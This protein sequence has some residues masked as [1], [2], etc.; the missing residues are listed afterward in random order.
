[1]SNI[2]KYSVITLLCVIQTCGV[3]WE[4]SRY[5][6]QEWSVFSVAPE[7]GCVAIFTSY[8]SCV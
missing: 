3:I 5:L 8:W 1:M 2:H 6:S 7:S 4:A